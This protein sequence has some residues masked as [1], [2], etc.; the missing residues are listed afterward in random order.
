MIIFY[1]VTMNI[2]PKIQYWECYLLNGLVFKYVDEF[3]DFNNEFN[4]KFYD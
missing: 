4:Y 1:I 2:C 3:N